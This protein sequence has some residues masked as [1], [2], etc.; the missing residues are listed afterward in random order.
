MFYRRTTSPGGVASRAESGPSIDA[1]K[2]PRVSLRDW[3][4]TIVI[5]LSA[6]MIIR[7]FFIEA[8]RIPTSSMEKTLLAGDFVVVSKLRYGPR[9]PLTVGLPFLN[10]YVPGVE[11]PGGRLPGFQDPNRGDVIVFNFPKEDAPIGRKT[12]YIKR[13]VGLP[14]DTL[15]IVDKVP[16]V[17]GRSVPLADD[18]QQKWLAIRRTSR[19]FP[20]DRLV[21]AGAEEIGRVGEQLDGVAFQSTVALAQEVGG[22]SEIE[23]VQPLV[24]P[25]NAARAGVVFPEGAGHVPD[26]YGPLHVPARGDSVRLTRVNVPAYRDV[27]ERYEGHD[28]AVLG[29]EVFV[30]GEPA[31]TYVVEKDYFFVMGDNRDSSF[32]SR[33]WGF[34]PWDHVV[35][36]ATLIYFSWDR[37]GKRPRYDRLFTPIR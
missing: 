18:M 4:L 27:V 6:A 9:L 25:R 12:H 10:L 15:S 20:I 2:K 8:F 13:I 5:A 23:S 22:W 34:V 30:D 1:G 26:N 19:T 31:A 21:D 35:G 33:I 11:L 36:K 14:G 17:N 28:L 24:T 37:T 32:D 29:D 3:L 7:G 16:Y